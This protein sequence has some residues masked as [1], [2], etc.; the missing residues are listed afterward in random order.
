MQEGITKGSGTQG[1]M[2]AEGARD[3]GPRAAESR[4]NLEQEWAS[5]D[6]GDTGERSPGVLARRG[7]G[8]GGLFYWCRSCT[9]QIG[10]A[11]G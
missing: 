1:G 11:H 4:E 5:H 3:H 7:R 10:R 2:K 9:A 8:G 6:G